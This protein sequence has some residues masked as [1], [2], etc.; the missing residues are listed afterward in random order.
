MRPASLIIFLRLTAM[1]DMVVFEGG[2]NLLKTEWKHNEAWKDVSNKND[3]H[4]CS[5]GLKWFQLLHADLH[6]THIP[7]LR[8]TCK[9]VFNYFNKWIN[10]K[11]LLQTIGIAI[12]LAGR[13]KWELSPDENRKARWRV[14]ILKEPW[15]VTHKWWALC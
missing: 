15:A 3:K 11:R 14:L 1:E 12:A 10:P 4:W 9:N 6:V 8:N 7:Q 5:K 2:F 13:H